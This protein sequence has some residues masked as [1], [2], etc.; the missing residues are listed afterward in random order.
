MSVDMYGLYR[1]E[2]VRLSG[3]LIIGHRMV[4]EAINL[5]LVELGYE[6]AEYDEYSWRYYKNLAGNYHQADNDYIRT[7]NL[8][9][10]P[11]ADPSYLPYILITIAGLSGPYQI[12]LT[13]DQVFGPLGNLSIATEYSTGSRSLEVLYTLY[14]EAENLIRGIFYPVDID[15]AVRSED[16]CILYC[17]GYVRKFL[18]NDPEASYFIESEYKSDIFKPLIEENEVELL[19]LLEQWIKNI[20]YRWVV[21]DYAT[22]NPYYFPLCLAM[23]YALLPSKIMEIRLEFVRTSKVHSYHISEFLASI[24]NLGGLVNIIPK[25]DIIYVYRNYPD[26]IDR[27][28]T[29]G[30]LIDLVTEFL[31]S[32]KIP[33][34]TYNVEHNTVN[35]V[36][37]KPLPV[38]RKNEYVN[39]ELAPKEIVE[40][41]Y[42][43]EK[44]LPLAPLNPYD[45]DNKTKDIID[46]VASAG[47]DSMTTKVVESKIQAVGDHLSITLVDLLISA[48]IYTSSTGQY[49]ASIFIDDP[50]NGESV[51]VTPATALVLATYCYVK[52]HTDAEITFIPSF[53][54]RVLPKVESF[55]PVGKSV[56][57]TD[58]YMADKYA[59]RVLLEDMARISGTYRMAYDYFSPKGFYEDVTRAFEEL[60]RKEYIFSGQTVSMT[61]AVYQH[62]CSQYYW[63]N[64]VVNLP[65]TGRKYDDFILTTGINLK[66]LPKEVYRSLF[67]DLVKK[68]TGNAEDSEE[69]A[70]ALMG[71]AMSVMKHFTGYS[72]QYLSEVIVGDSLELGGRIPR[73]HIEDFSSE[74]KLFNPLS[75]HGHDVSVDDDNTNLRSQLKSMSIVIEDTDSSIGQHNWDITSS[76]ITGMTDNVAMSTMISSYAASISVMETTP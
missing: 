48:W 43:I 67:N 70:K 61:R 37:Q 22:V 34:V 1:E 5:G 71:A 50:T 16:G 39:G 45:I 26:L 21:S 38:V 75:R 57:P 2:T 41:E 51:A 4:A 19:S 28:E 64:N 59:G 31:G 30:L 42:L 52:G 29:E 33:A 36:N 8:E 6:V 40:I 74:L 32:V 47:G 17:G 76:V 54:A 14:P 62:A 46:L 73:S 13:R 15:V 20:F 11:N 10:Y 66:G 63:L 60:G 53:F 72:V 55:T 68:A 44:E 58:V 18:G 23:I 35:Y 27:K 49:G 12:P 69:R 25:K 9:L 56:Y 65:V 24:G 3:T 7:R